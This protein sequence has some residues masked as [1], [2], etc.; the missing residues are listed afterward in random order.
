MNDFYRNNALIDSIRDIDDLKGIQAS[1]KLLHHASDDY[2]EDD[3]EEDELENQQLMNK[4][5]VARPQAPPSHQPAYQPYDSEAESS[6]NNIKFIDDQGP[7]QYRPD[8]NDPGSIEEDE[9]G[10]NE[11]DSE[12]FNQKAENPKLSSHKT[13]EQSQAKA[14][15]SHHNKS[16]KQESAGIKSNP[17]E[18]PPYQQKFSENIIGLSNDEDSEISGPSSENKTGPKKGVAAEELMQP[19]QEENYEDEYFD[20]DEEYLE[21][22]PEK[23]SGTF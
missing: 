23:D 9:D 19:P 22:E 5:S 16:E 13:S 17:S 15:S 7:H 8:S 6:E 20:A 21:N 10:E 2:D 18:N 14:S 12:E 3:D 1:Q 11:Y 4:S